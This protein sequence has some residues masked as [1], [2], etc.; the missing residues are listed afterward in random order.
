MRRLAAFG[1]AALL[2]L[3]SCGGDLQVKGSVERVVGENV[4]LALV[5]GEPTFNGQLSLRAS[6]HTVLDASALQANRMDER[7]LSFVIPAGIAAGSAVAVVGQSGGGTYEVPLRISR[8]AVVLDES[9]GLEAWPLSPSSLP[10][11]GFPT[12]TGPG[13]RLALSPTGGELAVVAGDEVRLLALGAEIRDIGAG[14]KQSGVLALAAGPA[15]QVLVATADALILFQFR[16]GEQ[17][18]Q[19]AVT[20]KDIR[21]LAIAS[22]GESAVVLY[23][24]DTNTDGILDAACLEKVLL[25]PSLGRDSGSR[26]PLDAGPEASVLAVS[27]DGKGVLVA[28]SKGIFGLYAEA[29]P[30]KSTVGWSVNGS[31]FTGAQPVGADR[32]GAVVSGQTV[33]LFAVAEK[34]KQLVELIAFNPGA[35]GTLQRV[36]T[37]PLSEPPSRISYGRRTQLYVAAGK[38]LLSVDVGLASPTVSPVAEVTPTANISGLVVQP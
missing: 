31:A 2:A 22:S 28:D 4:T 9:G 33:D 23:G 21:A 26:V 13:A 24:C 29:P 3:P 1:L 38:G 5:S 11:T 37:L 6:D 14:I 36:G 7:T 19:A 17:T 32:A 30:R 10:R 25:S 34:S 20:F 27:R 16:R 8:L 12:K 18:T 35:G 15:G